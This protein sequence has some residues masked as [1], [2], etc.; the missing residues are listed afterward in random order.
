MP[1]MN[2]LGYISVIWITENDELAGINFHP[3]ALHFVNKQMNSNSQ[4]QCKH[5]IPFIAGSKQAL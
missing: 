3:A 1:S 5:S 4:I 2:N